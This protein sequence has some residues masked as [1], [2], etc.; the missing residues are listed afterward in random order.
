MSIF[1]FFSPKRKTVMKMSDF[2]SLTTTSEPRFILDLRQCQFVEPLIENIPKFYREF[3]N[4]AMP[5]RRDQFETKEEYL[6][7]LPKPIDNRQVRYIRLATI[8]PYNN[9]SYDI[10][11]SMLTVYGKSN[12]RDSYKGHG[13]EVTLSSEDYTIREYENQNRFGATFSVREFR[14]T[15]LKILLE[16]ELS[17]FAQLLRETDSY[18]S[19]QFAIS[20]PMER[21]MAREQADKLSLILGVRLLSWERSS[22]EHYTYQSEP[23]IVRPQIEYRSD[24]SIDAKFVSLHLIN[25]QSKTQFAV[26]KDNSECATGG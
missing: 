20:V 17:Y 9:Y 18:H 8:Y 15:D 25:Y 7:R 12:A 14:Q 11:T 22:F 3:E 24:C 21:N 4:N 10:E 16:N 26:Y 1:D 13:T 23:T 2:P 5:P 6:Q 19:Q